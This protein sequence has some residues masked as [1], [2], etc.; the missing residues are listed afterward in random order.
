MLRKLHCLIIALSMFATSVYALEPYTPMKSIDVMGVSSP[1]VSPDGKFVAYV[2]S[3]RNYDQ[4]SSASDIYLLDLATK[5]SKPLRLTTNG[6]HNGSP[7]WSPDSKKLAFISDRCDD[8]GRQIYVLPI[9]GP[10]EAVRVTEFP[11]GV[12]DFIYASDGKSIVLVGRV[13]PDNISLETVASRD[14]IKENEKMHAKVHE[15][16]MYRHWDTYWDGKVTHLFR[17]DIGDNSLSDITPELK[18]DALNYWLM[19]AGREFSISPDSRWVYFSCNQDKDQ[20]V[21]YNSEVYRVPLSGGEIELISKNTAADNLPCPSP[22]G[23]YLAWRA[24][25]R[26][27]Y[28]SD[29]YSLVLLDLQSNNLTKLTG[30]FDRS[31]G[32]IIWSPSS[33]RIYFEAENMGDVDIYSVKV[34]STEVVPVVSYETGAG[35]GYR[36]HTAILDGKGRRFLYQY[37]PFE[38]MYEIAVYDSNKET[39]DLITDHNEKIFSE[40]YIPVGED[41]WFA[42]AGGTKIH[43]MIFKPI[44][45]D[46]SKKYPMLVRIHGGPQQMFGRAFR[47]EYALFAGRGY[48][49]FACNPRGSTGYGQ[50]LTDEIRGDWGGKVIEDIKSG[51]RYVLAN[52]SYV[53]KNGVVGWGGSF[54]G[55][56]CNWLAGH[57]EDNL[58]TALV[59]HAGD[60]DQWGAYGSTEELWFPEWEMHGPPW[61]SPD[62]YDELSPIRYAKD[63]NTP[64]LLTHGDLDWRVPVGGSEQM[65]TAL[66]RQGVPSKFVR[67][68]DEGHWILKPQNAVFWYQSILDW[69]DKWCK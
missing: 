24:T 20:A 60:A 67:F 8:L 14:S 29:K 55:F 61:E 32:N 26:P 34:G 4:N 37:R 28:E 18:Y 31:V 54:G 58:F 63:F 59:S 40:N 3:N 30:S 48:V 38:H 39:V 36:F 35:H 6:K 33:D 12:E 17:M 16:L 41:V 43:G 69:A 65:F 49:V 27:G 13:Y 51:V 66:Q 21:S 64:V 68:P 45:F 25:E 50:Q 7:C 19:S 2:L 15:A 52:Y 11:G 46:P 5:G 53:D 57:N 23:K 62:L 42:G 22:D 56:A 1:E 47:H 44:D 10:G 9:S